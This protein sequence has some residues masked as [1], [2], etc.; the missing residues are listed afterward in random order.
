VDST[1]EEVNDALARID[2]GT[3]G[4]RAMPTRLA[5]LVARPNRFRPSSFID[6]VPIGS[7]AV[8]F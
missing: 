7:M 6:A 8:V 1:Q 4:R 2:E 5:Q 3:L